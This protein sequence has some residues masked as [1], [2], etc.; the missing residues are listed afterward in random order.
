MLNLQR[1]FYSSNQNGSYCA[2]L[3]P[4]EEQKQHL[5]AAKNKIRDH[6]REG[7]ERASM[8][9]L[10]QSRK[11]SPRF[12]T[13]GSWSYN[14]C[15]QPAFMPP[16]EMDWDLGHYLPISVWEDSRPKVAASVYYQLLEQ[17]L[18]SLC[19]RER[20]T[21]CPKETCVRVQIGQHCHIDVPPYA[22]PDEEFAAIQERVL[23]KAVALKEARDATVAFCEMPETDWDSMQEIVLAT[24]SGEWKPS[25]PGV[26]SDWFRHQVAEHGEQLRRICRYLKG[27]RDFQWREGGPT[28][29]SLMICAC[30]SFQAM[31]GRDDLAL[32]EVARELGDKLSGDIREEL[33]NE[34]DDFNK[35]GPQ[36]RIESAKKA[37]TLHRILK[38]GLE[39]HRGERLEVL[40]SLRMQFGPRIPF[41]QEWI[42]D[43]TPQAVVRAAPALIVPQP[44][45]RRTKAG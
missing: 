44:E 12:R 7:V 17:L 4:T 14:T 42:T 6:L 43:D 36:E 30:Q 10:G 34:Q 33:I 19:D 29:V 26:V 9:V 16:Q 15:N 18:K 5:A 8:T 22:A 35:L 3:L 1:I 25:D 39:A 41:E 11:V 24:R 13:Q 40:K 20:W 45:V 38:D 21:L 27:W 31:Q 37:R 28:S 32:L 23:A 2:A